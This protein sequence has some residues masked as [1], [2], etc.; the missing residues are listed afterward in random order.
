MDE[1]NKEKWQKI[2]V[3]ESQ[4]YE[5]MLKNNEIENAKQEALIK[6]RSEAIKGANKI[7]QILE[8]NYMTKNMQKMKIDGEKTKSDSCSNCNYEFKNEEIRNIET[9]DIYDDIVFTEESDDEASF[10]LSKNEDTAHISVM[11]EA[12]QDKHADQNNIKIEKDISNFDNTLINKSDDSQSQ[13]KSDNS[14]SQNSSQNSALA[15]GHNSS[16]NSTIEIPYEY[17]KVVA[18]KSD[19]SNLHNSADNV[20]VPAARKLKK[21]TKPSLSKN[22]SDT[23]NKPLRPIKFFL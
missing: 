18:N 22:S 20:K 19:D 4:K 5:E 16:H 10:N 17:I 14:Q 21:I 1:R 9:V 7:T 6:A 8:T 3:E 13:N 2:I 15:T 11:F 12:I 23:P